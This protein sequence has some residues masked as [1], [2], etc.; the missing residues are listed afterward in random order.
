MCE[1]QKYLPPTFFNAQEHYLIHQVEEIELCGPVHTRSMWMVER[2][3]KSLKA[4]VRQ[5]ARPEGFMV[6]GY[7]LYQSMVYIS[8]YLPKLAANMHV[9]RIWDVKSIKKFEGEHLLGKGRM[10]KVKGN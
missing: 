8:Q 6:E 4:L 10:T 7:K 2:H 9:D 5:R 3:L 1:M